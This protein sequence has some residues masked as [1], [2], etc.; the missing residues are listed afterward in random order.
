MCVCAR[1]RGKLAQ[2]TAEKHASRREKVRACLATGLR[3]R[4]H[5]PFL[6]RRTSSR[7]DSPAVTAVTLTRQ[8][9]FGVASSLLAAL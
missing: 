8:L 7:R 2:S 4:Q 6:F 3:R 1:A 9:P 5:F